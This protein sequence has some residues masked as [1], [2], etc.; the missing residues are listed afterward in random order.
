[1]LTY[2]SL[3][4]QW[5]VSKY[6]WRVYRKGD[7]SSQIT[8]FDWQDQMKM[9]VCNW[10]KEILNRN[11]KNKISCSNFY[12]PTKRLLF[13]FYCLSCLVFS[14]FE[15]PVRL[16]TVLSLE[17]VNCFASWVCQLLGQKNRDI[18]FLEDFLSKRRFF[19]CI[20]PW[21]VLQRF[22]VYWYHHPTRFRQ[23][24]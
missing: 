5:K 19:G 8:F 16:L 20:F 9:R 2:I 14:H 3:L 23:T 24:D 7:D 11:D 18:F 10:N 13:I 6:L 22:L 12:R 15:F 1:M 4:N 21:L 17:S